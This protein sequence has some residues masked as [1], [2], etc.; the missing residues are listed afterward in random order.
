MRAL[1]VRAGD[2]YGR[3]TIIHEAK[4]RTRHRVFLCECDC[5]TR[6][7]VRLWILTSGQAKSC[8]CW[9]REELAGRAR[10]HGKCGTRLYS[11]WGS[12]RQRCLNPHHAT[13]QDYG[14]RGIA[15][16][17]EW[18]NH[19]AFHSWALANG[20][21]DDLTIERIDNNRGYE[22]AN[23]RW[24]PQGEQVLNTRRT[25]NLTY[26]GRTQSIKLWADELDMK[27][28]TLYHRLRLGWRVERAL[29]E[30]VDQRQSRG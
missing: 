13:Y 17:D 9:K 28:C 18:S 2:R 24:I 6:R 7:V 5:G 25:R 26:K 14:G 11:C 16:C 19:E 8:G 15:I 29:A 30:P 12:M 10:T 3:Y 23:C 20:Y 21:R 4:S 27:Y 1:P 22:P